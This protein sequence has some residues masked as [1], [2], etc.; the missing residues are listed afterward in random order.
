MWIEKRTL[1]NG[2]VSYRAVE[3]YIDELTGKRRRVS[4]TIDK[5]TNATVK[6]AQAEIQRKISTMREQ[7][8]ITDI[9]LAALLDEYLNHKKVFVKPATFRSYQ[10]AA[11]KVISIFPTGILAN[12]ITLAAAQKVFLQL[13][14]Y[15]YSTANTAAQIFKQTI[16]Y[17]KKMGYIT[18]SDYLADID[19]ISKKK[20]ADDV[21]KARDKFLTRAEL[22]DVLAQLRELDKRKAL[23]FEFIALTGLRF[24]EC[25]ALR[26]QDIRGDE[27]SVNGT[28]VE[29][30]PVDSERKRGTPKT[31]AS[32][33]II[34]LNQRAKDIISYMLAD[35]LRLAKWT[36][37][38]KDCGY[39][40]TT[41]NGNPIPVG[42]AN[43][44]LS[45]VKI[46]KHLTTHIFRHTHISLLAELGVPL[47][48]IMDRVGHTNP[49]TT[50][51]IYSH[52]TE[53]M[54]KDV[55]SKLDA[56][57]G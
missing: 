30:L 16:R 51:S 26:G 25:T 23:M 48:T 20:T 32:V 57:Y 1:K 18:R 11:K 34:T 12:A 13:G 45:R 10:Q 43:K 52:V 55:A 9:T 33:R 31:L 27:I 28:I 17:G 3:N 14:N 5:K 41:A 35:N 49:K 2:T 56:L 39:I 4:V 54:K 53:E 47:K 7:P 15:S 22:A 37:R 24:G 46:D 19:I 42:G 29:H 8:Q 44:L 38:Y 40:F 6:W 36:H 50:L 21:Q